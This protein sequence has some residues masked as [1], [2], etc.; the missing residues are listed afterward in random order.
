MSVM[1]PRSFD[2]VITGAALIAGAANVI[3]QLAAPGVGYGVYESPVE[4]GNVARHPFK[5]M[6]TTFTYLAVAT[7]GTE[8]EKVAYRKAVNGSH[9]QVRSTTDSPVEYNAFNTELQLWVAAC[10]YKGME[11]VHNALYPGSNFRGQNGIYE[12]AATLGTTLQVRADQ[13]PATRE[14]FD[15][16]WDAKLKEV[17]IDDTIRAYLMRLVD[18]E[19]LPWPLTAFRPIN[20]FFTTGFLPKELREQMRLDWSPADQ[21]RFDR[22]LAGYGRVNRRLPLAVRQFPLSLYLADLR[23]R[24]KHGKPLV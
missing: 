12:Q 8:A 17:H 24:M 10:L 18:L 15:A 16:Y 21:R 2:D 6:R 22:I 23:R 4:S 14:D 20:R 9:R 3:M 1:N 7:Y 5:R 13:W 11:D 19:V